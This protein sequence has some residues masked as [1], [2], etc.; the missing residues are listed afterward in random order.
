MSDVEEVLNIEKPKKE[1]REKKRKLE[2]VEEE[3]EVG[4]DEALEAERW[5]IAERKRIKKERKKIEK[6][7][8]LGGKSLNY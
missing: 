7:E 1:K 6:E 2:T 5:N 3:G 4:T 8:I